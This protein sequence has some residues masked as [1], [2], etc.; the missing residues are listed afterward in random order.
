MTGQE[1]IQLLLDLKDKMS[2]GVVKAKRAVNK[3]VSEIKKRLTDLKIHS[4]KTFTAMRSQIPILDRGLGL[5]CNKYVM[6]AAVLVGLAVGIGKVTKAAGDFDHAFLPIKQL[7]LD[8]SRGQLEVYKNDI[9]DVAFK[10]GLA[11]KDTAKAFYDIQSA[12]GLYGKDVADITR[13][14][15]NFSIATGA[16]LPDA[17]NQTVKAMKAFGLGV[18]DID[19]LLISNAKTV[20]VAITTFDELAQYQ[21][22]Y[23]GAASAAGQSIDTANKIFAAFTSIAKDTRTAA[24]MTKTAFEGLTQANTIKG[25]KSIGIDMYDMKGNLKS[26]DVILGQVSKKFDGMSSKQID[27]LINDIGGPEGLRNMFNKLKTGSEDFFNTMKQ[28]DNVT[29]NFQDALRNAKGDMTTL[30]NIARNRKNILMIELGQ[31]FLPMWVAMLEKVNTG[32]DYVYKNFDTIWTVTKNVGSA[33]LVAKA[34]M[35]AFNVVSGLN[36]IGGMYLAIVAIIGGITFGIKKLKEWSGGWDNLGKIIGVWWEI[37]KL[38]MQGNFEEAK[39][40]IEIM[41]ARFASFFDYLHRMW[42]R[43]AETKDLALDG[44]FKGIKALWDQKISM[45]TSGIEELK[46]MRNIYRGIYWDQRNGLKQTIDTI[47]TSGSITANAPQIGGKTNLSDY[48][49]TDNNSTPLGDTSVNNVVGSASTPR[50]ITINIDA[51]NKG[52]IRVSHTEADGMDE[53]QL[54]EWFTNMLL[55]ITNSVA[56]S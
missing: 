34:L 24:T 36:P 22:E 11:A 41:K 35:I 14:V 44:N 23:A 53:D 7:N 31:K 49:K 12:T 2:V 55:R 9:L 21:T 3:N 39:Y 56:M 1:R 52:D 16:Q 28:Y 33:L 42:Q 13:K 54:E 15:G 17:V 40:G 48:I 18:N 30:A 8:K 19:A 20:Q 5:L 10:T 4:A 25:L 38:D 26:V 51:L 47:R 45:D 43:V 29:F 6:T 37:F 27:K 32:L 46:D 50:S